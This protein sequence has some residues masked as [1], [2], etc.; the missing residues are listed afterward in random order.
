MR[1]FILTFSY[2]FLVPGLLWSENT[3]S[4][5][6][7][8]NKCEQLGHKFDTKKYEKKSYLIDLDK[9]IVQRINIITK[10]EYDRRKKEYDNPATILK[11]LLEKIEII[12][13]K[14]E[15][16]DK[17]FVKANHKI[18]SSMNKDTLLLTAVLEIDLAEKIVTSGFKEQVV[19]PI[20]FKCY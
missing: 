2:L 4:K 18:N 11:P 5:P 13:Y 7:Q 8:I 20:I 17:R 9:S 15:Y 10:E 3:Y 14:I 16:S 12:D 6:I 19:A 1:T